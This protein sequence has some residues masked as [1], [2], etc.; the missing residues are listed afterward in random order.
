[1]RNYYKSKVQF[2][3]NSIDTNVPHI[4]TI[5]A[6]AHLYFDI[7]LCVGD[8]LQHQCIIIKVS[9]K[10]SVF[11]SIDVV[12]CLLVVDVRII[13]SKALN[14][15]LSVHTHIWRWTTATVKTYFDSICQLCIFMSTRYIFDF[16]RQ[17][18]LSLKRREYDSNS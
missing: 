9:C 18:A 2:L 4:C 6:A 1:M 16:E 5:R 11:V 7:F 15:S 17:M 14:Y 3:F 12:E 8:H 13:F 10:V